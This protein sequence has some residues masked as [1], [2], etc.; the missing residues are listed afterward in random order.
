M[1][2]GS[3]APKT[4][5]N[6]VHDLPLT[7]EDLEENTKIL[8]RENDSYRLYITEALII[9][10]KNPVLNLQATGKSRTLK[11]TSQQPRE[12][13]QPTSSNPVTPHGNSAT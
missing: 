3:G 11:L 5:Y 10:S 8:R 13:Q 9:Q 4:H 7:R 2:K 1:H 6:Q 12:E